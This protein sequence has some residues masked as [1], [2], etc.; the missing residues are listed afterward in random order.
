MDVGGTIYG[1]ASYYRIHNLSKYTTIISIHCANV[2]TLND[3]QSCVDWY[4]RSQLQQH[5]RTHT[6]THEHHTYVLN[7]KYRYSI[8]SSLRSNSCFIKSSTY[9][10]K[11]E[12]IEV[13]DFCII[14]C[15]PLPGRK[16]FCLLYTSPSPRD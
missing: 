15:V 13:G 9:S 12:F 16:S 14:V 3:A 11:S 10:Y 7:N 5:H 8:H 1:L 2:R 6:H 4:Y